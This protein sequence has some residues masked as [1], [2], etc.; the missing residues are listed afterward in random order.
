MSKVT[1]LGGNGWS[2]C[3][4]DTQSVL[5]VVVPVMADAPVVAV[6]T[7]DERE[8]PP[9]TPDPAPP[10]TLKTIWPA[11]VMPCWFVVLQSVTPGLL[12]FTSYL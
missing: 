5:V 11:N 6:V 10:D 4:Q 7:P 12:G 8:A 9:A 2:T 1:E 3:W